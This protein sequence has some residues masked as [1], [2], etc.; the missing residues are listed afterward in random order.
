[1]LN[2]HRKRDS[3][4]YTPRKSPHAEQVQDCFT[5]AVN[6]SHIEL[7]CA[8][9][10]R[11]HMMELLLQLLFSPMLDY[12]LQQQA[13][14]Q[15]LSII[16]FPV[17]LS[18]SF[19]TLLWHSV[20]SSS[21]CSSHMAHRCALRNHVIN[22]NVMIAVVGARPLEMWAFYTR[23]MTWHDVVRQQRVYMGCTVV[24]YSSSCTPD[25]VYAM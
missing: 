6:T 19:F 18:F 22:H 7:V 20:A 10:G 13:F 11:R 14:W 4:R 24:A 16:S 25:C 1:M 17:G 8:L 2:L 3:T 12:D 9:C 21:A 15:L 23:N 5:S